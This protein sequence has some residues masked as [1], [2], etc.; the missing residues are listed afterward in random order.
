MIAVLQSHASKYTPSRLLM[1][2]EECNLPLFQMNDV[3]ICA[4]VSKEHLESLDFDINE[5]TLED[6]QTPTVAAGQC[7]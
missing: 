4:F 5:L 3:W 6:I 7:H 2:R 1:L